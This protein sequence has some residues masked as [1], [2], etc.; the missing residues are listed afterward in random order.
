M[1][2]RSLI[3]DKGLVIE[4]EPSEWSYLYSHWGADRI[5]EWI[6]ERFRDYRTVDYGEELDNEKSE[7]MG[8]ISDLVARE[9]DK[10]ETW[11][12]ASN[13]KDLV[14]LDNIQFE[15]YVIINGLDN[16]WLVLPFI[17]QSLHGGIIAKIFSSAYENFV[18][19]REHRR[20]HNYVKVMEE[21]EGHKVFNQEKIKEVAQNAFY[22]VAF[23][24]NYERYLRFDHI[25]RM[26][27]DMMTGEAIRIL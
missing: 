20:A 11:E 18:T 17:A 23:H 21:G 8:F 10:G 22:K 4:G 16:T 9:K 13:L 24:P 26:T 1:G 7:F 3:I 25:D 12:S 27:I 14:R 19:L 15:A 5:K 2:A 6:E